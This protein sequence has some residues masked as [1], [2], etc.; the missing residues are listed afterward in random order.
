MLLIFGLVR[1]IA[2]PSLIKVS[3]VSLHCSDMLN[4]KFSK[5]FAKSL[6]PDMGV[7]CGSSALRCSAAWY[8]SVVLLLF[9]RKLDSC[10]WIRPL[11]GRLEAPMYRSPH[12]LHFAL[13][14]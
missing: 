8:P 6:F 1:C 12:F 3:R 2:K 10:S 13:Y 14:T 7:Y 4:S 5:N 9:S 11:T